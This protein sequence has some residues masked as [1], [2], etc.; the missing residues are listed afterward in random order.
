MKQD[1]Q[2][3][4]WHSLMIKKVVLQKL[5]V[6]QILILKA[7]L[8]IL[9]NRKKVFQAYD[10]IQTNMI[11]NTQRLILTHVYIMTEELLL[12]D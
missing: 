12:L 7:G 1:F 5:F 11:L 3:E 4:T 6:F 2:V 9:L 8:L 10:L